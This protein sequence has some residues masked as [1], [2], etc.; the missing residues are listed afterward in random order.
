MVQRSMSE[1]KMI[2]E[3][4]S[5]SFQASKAS[6]QK[7]RVR[8]NFVNGR[9]T[10]IREMQGGPA[11]ADEDVEFHFNPITPEDWRANEAPLAD[12]F[13]R[14]IISGEY[15]R[16]RLNIPEEDGQGTMSLP[17]QKTPTAPTDIVTAIG[18]MQVRNS[19]DTAWINVGPN[20]IASE[21][22]VPVKIMDDSGN[23]LSMDATG[24]PNVNIG[25]N[26]DGAGKLLVSPS[27]ASANYGSTGWSGAVSVGWARSW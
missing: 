13:Q 1:R 24:K 26:F 20:N 12:L 23:S 2:K 15:V 19:A 9:V 10:R 27:T 17:I 11:G 14:G 6:S 4:S 8:V 5:S 16:D 25:G 22:R 7:T 3:T 18:Q 21:A